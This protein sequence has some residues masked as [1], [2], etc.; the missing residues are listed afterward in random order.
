[1]SIRVYV[2]CT[3]SKDSGMFWKPVCVHKDVCRVKD[4]AGDRIGI[5][6]PDEE[7]RLT[8]LKWKNSLDDSLV[9]PP[10]EYL[11]FVDVKDGDKILVRFCELEIK[12]KLKEKNERLAF[13]PL[14]PKCKY[15]KGIK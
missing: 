8:F 2:A 14:H 4:L 6:T 3:L 10:D 15:F 12:K 7:E 13:R 9:L 11:R 5:L 1:M